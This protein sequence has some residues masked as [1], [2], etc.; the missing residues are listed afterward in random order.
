MNDD[1]VVK[2]LVFNEARSTPLDDTLEVFHVEA[3]CTGAFHD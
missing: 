2:L 3:P 1:Q